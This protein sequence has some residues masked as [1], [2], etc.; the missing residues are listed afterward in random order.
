MFCAWFEFNMKD[1][2]NIKISIDNQE[3]RE[4]ERCANSI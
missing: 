2:A 3:F 4:R 1:L